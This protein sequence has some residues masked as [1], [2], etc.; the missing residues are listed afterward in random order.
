MRKM[1]VFALCMGMVFSLTACGQETKS[2]E[3]QPKETATIEHAAAQ[4]SDT[5]VGE[6]RQAESPV[7]AETMSK[8]LEKALEGMEGAS[9]VPVAYLGSQILNGTNHAILCRVAPVMPDAAET[10]AIVYLNESLDGAVTIVKI[11]ESE[12]ETDI[13]DAPGGW[14][15]SESPVVTEEVR[16]SLEKALDGAVGAIYNPIAVVSSQVVAGMNYCILCEVTP[17]VPDAVSTYSLVYLYVDLDENAEITEMADFAAEADNGSVQI[18]S[19]FVDYASIE[20]AA[21]IAGFALI[22]PDH[23]DGFS[24]KVV[25]VMDTSMI[26]VLYSEGEN[27]LFIRKAEGNSDISGDNNNYTQSN[28]VAVGNYEV[29]MRG[30]NG[31]V[32]VA[33]WTDGGYTYSVAGDMPMTPDVVAALISQIA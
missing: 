11:I 8:N 29:T 6:W 15:Q 22:A 16:A 28:T 26:Q 32:S 2:Q 10:Y 19:P 23:V 3:E 7:V 12:K 20:D 18:P 31:T 13:S 33:I 30:E 14:F 25:Q 21:K 27:R 17:V 5:M 9:Y 1:I 4:E 24:E